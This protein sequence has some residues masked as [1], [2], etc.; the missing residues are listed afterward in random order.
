MT[1]WQTFYEEIKSLIT[2]MQPQAQT[3]RSDLRQFLYNADFSHDQR[4]LLKSRATLTL[5]NAF[6]KA[7]SDNEEYASE[8]CRSFVDPVVKDLSLIQMIITNP[9]SRNPDTLIEPDALDYDEKK[10]LVTRLTSLKMVL[11]DISDNYELMLS[12]LDGWEETE[13]KSRIDRYR[14]HTIPV[15]DEFEQS[16]PGILGFSNDAASKLR[17]ASRENYANGAEHLFRITAG[18]WNS[19]DLSTP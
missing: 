4:T 2:S 11:S 3:F 16:I 15:L 17:Q 5:K 19:P 18:L 13:M 12:H 6:E 1:P 14:T 10:L 8:L 7:G 9:F